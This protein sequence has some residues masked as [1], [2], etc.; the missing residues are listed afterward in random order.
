MLFVRVFPVIS[1]L[2]C[3]SCLMFD[4]VWCDY[5]CVCD[6]NYEICMCLM[7]LI[8]NRL[9]FVRWFP[10]FGSGVCLMFDQWHL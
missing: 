4:A 8:L 2:L 5:V 6:I 7:F 3:D 1:G 9:D 10:L